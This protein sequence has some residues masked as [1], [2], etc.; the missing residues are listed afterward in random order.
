MQLRE[1]VC[2]RQHNASCRARISRI[3]DADP[4]VTPVYVVRITTYE[5]GNRSRSCNNT[6]TRREASRGNDEASYSTCGDTVGIQVCIAQRRNS[7]FVLFDVAG[8][9]DNGN[10]CNCTIL[11]LSF[12]RTCNSIPRFVRSRG[13]LIGARTSFDVRCSPEANDGCDRR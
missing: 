6:P 13:R 7:I 2:A 5:R 3:R 10:T 4:V 12:S 11:S 8:R 1:S 9:H